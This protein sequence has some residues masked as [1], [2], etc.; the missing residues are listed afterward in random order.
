MTDTVKVLS[1]DAL[2]EIEA[3]VAKATPAPLETRIGSGNNVCTALASNNPA[4]FDDFVCDVLPDYACKPGIATRWEANREFIQH[5]YSDIPALCATVR[6]LKE[7][8]RH[9][10]QLVDRIR[11]WS[12]CEDGYPLDEHIN[13]IATQNTALREQLA[14]ARHA[15]DHWAGLYTKVAADNTSLVNQPTELEG[16]SHV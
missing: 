13:N 16:K 7:V 1:D 2:R 11:L 15:V 9:N 6:A 10:A 14:E 4:T 5:A 3:R 8:G 12:K